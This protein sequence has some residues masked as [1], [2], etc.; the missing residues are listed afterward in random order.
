[1]GSLGVLSASFE[2]IELVILPQIQS[3]DKGIDQDVQILVVD[4]NFYASFAITSVLQ[5][6]Q[7]ES[8]YA[9]DGKEAFEM[10]K[11]RFEE[12]G[13]TYSLIIMDIF[14]PVCNGFEATD[15]IRAYL[16]GSI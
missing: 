5:Q 4:D 14:M 11:R 7:L 15:M 8:H 1:M 9:S 10:V 2:A 3:F 6:Y 16:A 13:K 12:T